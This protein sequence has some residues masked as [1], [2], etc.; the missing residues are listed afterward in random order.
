M[1]VSSRPV[2]LTLKGGAMSVAVHE[3]GGPGTGP[4][5]PK[6]FGRRV[7]R[8]G[9]GIFFASISLNAALGILALLAP[10]FGETQG[11]ILGTSLCVTGA[12]L[13]ALACEPAWER[14]LLG[15]VPYAGAVLGSVGFA[16]AIAIIWSEPKGD[17]WG[18]L[19]GSTFTLAVAACL[20][21]LLALAPLAPRHHWL[22]AIT[23]GLLALSTA[24]VTAL[25]WLGDEPSSSYLRAMGV[26]LIALAAFAV[27]VPVLHWIDRGALAASNA[28]TGAIRFCPHC[29]KELGG[30]IGVELRCGRCGRGFTITAVAGSDPT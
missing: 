18:K 19:I 26:V 30:E 6:V 2:K 15:P 21:S 9:L 3:L 4:T 14:S 11:K 25:W 24:M 8:V 23:L 12:I 29:G 17:I 20:A 5:Q 13:L 28:A 22:F 16:L 1:A 27:T 7:R 10:D